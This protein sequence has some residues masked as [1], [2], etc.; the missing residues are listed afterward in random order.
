MFTTGNFIKLIKSIGSLNLI[1]SIFEIYSISEDG[2]IE[3]GNA[4]IGKGVMDEEA[5]NKNFCLATEDEI[6]LYKE[7]ILPVR[8]YCDDEED[9][10]EYEE[11]CDLV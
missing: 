8:F 3:F 5:A 6:E 2:I 1:D 7:S 11:D 4:H 10:S 9:D